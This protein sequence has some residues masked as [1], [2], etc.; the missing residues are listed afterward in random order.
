MPTL[1]DSLGHADGIGRRIR[2]A[3]VRRGGI[4]NAR[5]MADPDPAKPLDELIDGG[6]IVMLMTM[7]GTTTRRGR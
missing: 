7:I 5:H 6:T 1:E 4:G 3:R 2:V